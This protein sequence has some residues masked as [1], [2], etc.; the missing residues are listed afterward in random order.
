MYYCSNKKHLNNSNV[1]RLIPRSSYLY[2]D[3]EKKIF[4]NRSNRKKNIK[5]QEIVIIS[6]G[7]GTKELENAI[8]QAQAINYNSFEDYKKLEEWYRYIEPKRL[9]LEFPGN[10]IN[11]INFLRCIKK[12]FGLNSIIHFSSATRDFSKDIY[13]YEL[14]VFDSP[15]R[16]ALALHPNDT[17]IIS[18]KM[19]INEDEY[20]QEEYDVL[21]EKGN[22]VN[23]IRTYETPLDYVISK[24]VIDAVNN[25]MLHFPKKYPDTF[26]LRI[27]SY[28]NMY[29]IVELIPLE[30][31][32]INQHKIKSNTFSESYEKAY[33]NKDIEIDMYRN[34]TK[35]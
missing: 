24:E 35:Q 10:M 4:T 12:L 18:E 30:L 25:I 34:L 13:L 16:L 5:G 15:I 20:G 1:K 2:Y 22:I 28:Q 14:L 29:E 21:V 6:D 33:F 27:A 17:F 32:D 3:E 8:T 23:I 7:L 31:Y 26:V 19:V 11:D 9:L